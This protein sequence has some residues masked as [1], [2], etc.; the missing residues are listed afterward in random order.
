MGLG[1]RLVFLFRGLIRRGLVL[2]VIYEWLSKD[3]F[4]RLR[5]VFFLKFVLLKVMR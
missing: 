5:L 3:L 2:G 1:F 4:F